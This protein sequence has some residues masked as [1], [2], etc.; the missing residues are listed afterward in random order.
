[1]LSVA[2]HTKTYLHV[3]IHGVIYAHRHLLYCVFIY[4]LTI[5]LNN[6][7]KFSRH[8]TVPARRG[9][10][11]RGRAGAVRVRARRWDAALPPRC[12]PRPTLTSTPSRRNF[13]TT[14]SPNPASNA[15]MQSYR[16]AV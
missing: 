13:L 4:S 8:V 3:D 9:H 15:V 6:V 10:G 2:E 12:E 1:M 11:V 5:L 7:N 14:G 16:G